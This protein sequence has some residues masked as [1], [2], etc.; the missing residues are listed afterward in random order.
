MHV[1]DAWITPLVSWGGWRVNNNS[2]LKKTSF[3]T[4]N[5]YICI[6]IYNVILASPTPYVILLMEEIPNNHLRCVEPREYCDNVPTNLN[7]W[8]PDFWTINSILFPRHFRRWCLFSQGG[9]CDR[10]LE[11]KY[12]IFIYTVMKVDGATPKNVVLV[13]GP[14]KKPIHGSVAPSTLPGG[15]TFILKNSP[16]KNRQ[17][18]VIP[19]FE[20]SVVSGPFAFFWR[21]PC[22]SAP[23]TFM[24]PK[25]WGSWNGI[26]FS[27]PGWIN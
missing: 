24:A 2:Y 7:W 18:R 25:S 4:H 26:F 17:C 13:K 6:Y 9:I 14:W 5:I 27:L 22:V 23:W 16:L 21:P 8:S 12:T 3:W 15:I 11:D 20:V 1:D 19:S 10:S